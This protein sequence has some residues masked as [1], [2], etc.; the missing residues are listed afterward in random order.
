MGNED[1]YDDMEEWESDAEFFD[2]E[3]WEGLV[4]YRRQKA[5]K[6]PNDPDY[7]W[8][9]G[10]AYM[11]NKEYEKAID[12][13]DGLHKKY[14][15]DPNIQHS[16]L[17]ALLA[18]GKDETATHWII[19]PK[20]LRL[21]NNILDCCYN[22][23]KTKRKRKRKPRTVHELH[24]ELCCEGYPTFDDNQLM[25]FLLSDNRFMFTG[26]NDKSYDCYIS[27]T[28]KRNIFGE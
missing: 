19:K 27:V 1:E 12:F 25:H 28:R 16:L 20:I 26:R 10:E 24:L 21:D 13:L 18:I 2:Q 5:E 9:L 15:D 17:D 8:S 14:P 22:F 6:Y 23:L 7:Q 3:D 11:L 4:E